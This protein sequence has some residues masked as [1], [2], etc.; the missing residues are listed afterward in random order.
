MVGLKFVVWFGYNGTA[1]VVG[2]VVM[3]KNSL[4]LLLL[5]CVGVLLGDEVI[6][7]DGKRLNGKA[8]RSQNSVLLKTPYGELKIPWEDVERLRYEPA[9]SVVIYPAEK[10]CL[11]RGVLLSETATEFR[12]RVKGGA[13]VVIEK[14]GKDSVEF[15]DAAA[16][17]AKKKLKKLIEEMV[18]QAKALEGTPLEAEWMRLLKAIHQLDPSNDYAGERLGLVKVGGVWVEYPFEYESAEFYGRDGW[19]VR[20]TPFV[21]ETDVPLKEVRKVVEAL[22]W[23]L[24]RL[25]RAFLLGKDAKIPDVRIVLFSDRKLY[26]EKTGGEGRGHYSYITD[27]LYIVYGEDG[28]LEEMFADMAFCFADVVVGVGPEWEGEKLKDVG[29]PQWL[30]YG[31]AFYLRGWVLPFKKG[32]ADSGKDDVNLG[33]PAEFLKKAKLD[34]R[35]GAYCEPRALV[36]IPPSRLERKA[37]WYALSLVITL[38]H[39]RK[40]ATGY[41]RMWEAIKEGKR[42][43]S[44]YFDPFFDHRG[45]KTVMLRM[46]ARLAGYRGKIAE[47]GTYGI[48]YLWHEEALELLKGRHLKAAIRKYRAI[49]E[50]KPKDYIALYNLACAYSLAGDKHN[51]SQFLLKAYD[52]G[53]KDIE[54]IKNDPDLENIRGTD[55]YRAIVGQ[56]K[57]F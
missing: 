47:R 38:V 50:L 8:E 33:L 42:H 6:L 17:E 26:K 53:F 55:I 5:L 56:K 51:G 41:R 32:V 29:A 39:D 20:A 52:A 43:P 7:K 3:L 10:P 54:H 15:I 31:L 37:F 11:V 57:D 23:L 13:V 27:T 24:P 4:L 49:I 21:I 25:R 48:T 9:R 19:R 12:V 45:V 14:S 34:L 36:R 40:F 22:E 28:W 2:F 16:A 35:D 44:D 18:A 46:L 1:F 30:L